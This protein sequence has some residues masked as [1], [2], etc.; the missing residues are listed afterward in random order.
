LPPFLVSFGVGVAL[1]YFYRGAKDSPDD[2]QLMYGPEVKA[3]GWL[4]FSLA[5]AAIVVM[6]AVDHDGQY[7]AISGIAAMCGLIGIWL[8]TASYLTSG[9]FN[10]RQISILSIWGQT[11]VGRWTE[12]QQ[13]AFKKNGQYFDLIFSDG[14]KI[15]LS[16]MLRGHR[17]VCEYLKSIGV[18][19][20]DYPED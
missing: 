13:A 11:R 5:V 6:F 17:A 20:T 8:L 18:T 15:G 3:L 7:L 16:K 12:L 2:G 4:S 1:A 9:H 19:V 14:T 10:D